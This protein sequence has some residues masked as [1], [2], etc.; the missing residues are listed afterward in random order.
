MQSVPSRIWTRVVVSIS[1]DDNHYTTGTFLDLFSRLL[2]LLLIITALNDTVTFLD[3]FSRLLWLLLI[4]TLLNGRR[5]IDWY[6]QPSAVVIFI[7]TVFKD[8]VPLIDLFPRLLCL[9]LIIT[10]FNHPVPITIDSSLKVIDRKQFYMWLEIRMIYFV[11]WLSLSIWILKSNI[12]RLSTFFLY[13]L[14]P[15]L[16][17]YDLSSSD[18]IILL[19]WPTIYLTA[20]RS[21]TSHL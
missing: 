21:L 18:Y 5:E 6:I 1:Y 13:T 17:S 12:S 11:L 4:I 10:V 2:C 8:T 19:Y 3:L 9:L 15:L 14:R 16:Q 20:V 7:I